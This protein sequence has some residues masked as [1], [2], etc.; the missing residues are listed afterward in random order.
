LRIALIIERFE[1]GGG[2]ENVAWAV[3]HRLADRGE[4]VRVV[5]RTA[6]SSARVPVDLAG[7]PRSWQPLRVLAFS[8]AAARRAPRGSVDVVHSFSRTRHQDVY[9]AGGGCHAAYLEQT[10]HRPA[11]GWRRFSPRHAVLL[12]MEERVFADTSQLVQCNSALVRDQIRARFA[13]P[14]DRLVVL[15]NGVDTERFHPRRRASEGARLRGE[16]GAASGPVWL[17][18]GS[19]LRR[20]GLDTALAAFACVRKPGAELWVAGRDDPTPWRALAERLGVG[21]QVRFLGPR[22]DLEAVYGAADA[23]LLPT[24]YDAF[25]NVCLEAAAAGLPVVTSAANGAA[26]ALRDGTLVVDDAED[27]RGFAGAL[28]QLDDPSLRRRLGEAGRSIAETLG[29]DEHVRRLCD[30]YARVAA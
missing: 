27:V 29:W 13:V 2:A 4:T 15:P 6:H 28:E 18:V 17:L 22:S 7:I 3:A 9:R 19:G 30:L 25:A 8:A 20:K 12:G 10:H 16:L 26:D 23:L 5:A 24:R 21:E 14:A 11:G 1:P